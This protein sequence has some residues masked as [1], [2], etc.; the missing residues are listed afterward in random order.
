MK[1]ITCC[2]LAVFTAFS[3]SFAT[4]A[5]VM[6]SDDPEEEA[7]PLQTN[8]PG[9][10]DANLRGNTYVPIIASYNPS[11]YRISLEFLYN[12]GDIE[13]QLN[14]LTAGGSVSVPTNTN[15]GNVYIPI[16]LGSGYYCL[17]FL[18]DGVTMY[19]G[20]FNVL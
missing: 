6:I 15:C 14:N 19:Y 3:L 13:I 5:S 20:Y 16:V 18:I 11:L 4:S 1:K 10:G 12:I 17:E 7:I 9:E 2:L 8:E